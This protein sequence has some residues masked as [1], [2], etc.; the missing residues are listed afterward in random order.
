[1]APSG[2]DYCHETPLW[3]D[4]SPVEWISRKMGECLHMQTSTWLTSR[5]LAEAAGPWDAR[6]VSDDDGEYFCRVLMAS[7]GT[8]F[9]PEAKVFYRNTASANRV[10]Y[11]GMSER[12]KDA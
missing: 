8:R 10:S 7:K 6:L 5:E 3:H 9:V 11:I 12:K 2:E 1:M 4:L